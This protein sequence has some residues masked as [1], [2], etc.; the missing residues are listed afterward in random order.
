MTD[1]KEAA[2]VAATIGVGVAPGTDATL[3]SIP[4][5]P[6]AARAR[7][8]LYSKGLEER[9]KIAAPDAIGGFHSQQ[10]LTLNPLGKVPLLLLKDSVPL[11]ESGVI[12]EYI[13][14][15]YAK[16]GRSF[17]PDDI[18]KRARTRLIASLLDQYVS[19]HHHYMYKG[20]MSL[21]DRKAGASRMR[22]GFDAIEVAIC[23]QGPYVGGDEIGVGDAA[24]W[25]CMPFYDFMLPAFFGWR[26]QDG[27]PNIARW[28]RDMRAEPHAARVY[29]EVWDALVDWWHGGRWDKI[30]VPAIVDPTSLKP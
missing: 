4:I 16:T 15:K 21:T 22:A 5:S 6:F 13:T 19:P 28:A 18:A 1:A 27:H 25:G 2:P 30:E 7:L 12:T 26:A 20:K 8:V 9:V 23:S 17:L 10:H 24:L 3:I 14:E 29:D 11:F